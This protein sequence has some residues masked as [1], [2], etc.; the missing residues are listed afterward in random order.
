MRL[1]VFALD[2]RARYDDRL[3]M[4]Q[5]SDVVCYVR[6]CVFVCA[7]GL[8]AES[9]DVCSTRDFTLQRTKKKHRNG[10]IPCETVLSSV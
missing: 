9:A 5:C 10:W 3:R 1:Y 4:G 8:E 2:T 7:F 6:A